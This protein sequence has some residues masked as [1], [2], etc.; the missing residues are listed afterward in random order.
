VSIKSFNNFLFNSFCSCLGD[1]VWWWLKAIRDYTELAPDSYEILNC[2]VLR[3]YP[4]DDST[5]PTDEDLKERNGTVASL[6]SIIQ[7]ALEGHVRG[8]KFRERNAGLKIDEHMLDEGFNNEIG[9]DLETGFVFGG[10]KLNC[11][12]WMDKL[13]SSSH[14]GNKG[15]PATPRDGSA[16]ELVGLSRSALEWLITAHSLGKYPYD[17]VM[18][19]TNNKIK[20]TWCEWAQRIDTNFEKYFWVGEDS[21]ESVHINKR[22][23]YKDTLNSTVPW[24]D[25][26]LRPNFLIAITVAPQM[27][28]KE[29]ARKAL[30]QVR[31]YLVNENNSVGIKTLGELNHLVNFGFLVFFF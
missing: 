27:I 23:I 6:A 25:Y 26:Q 12:T 14:A 9:V 19:D 29:H 21:N 13:G 4:N 7:E 15:L 31:D 5:H 1:A 24:T 20:Y 11:G 28:N 2:K 30:V 10:N 17:S 18:I 3:L 8:L 16:V 22:N